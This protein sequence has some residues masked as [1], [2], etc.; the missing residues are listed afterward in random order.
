MSFPFVPR[1]RYDRAL[2]AER[3]TTRH[4]AQRLDSMGTELA[5]VREQLASTDQAAEHEARRKALADALGEDKQHYTWDQLITQV[6]GLRQAG[7]DWMATADRE[8]SRAD[9]LQKVVDSARAR[10]AED[11]E[12]ARPVDGGSA[13]PLSSSARLRREK[14]RA[15]KLAERL[16]EVTA[17]NQAC[18]CAGGDSE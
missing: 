7:I 15:D 17:A 14:G 1:S 2:A 6:A 3:A 11:K 10:A 13:G 9:G 8:R 18:T 16:A 4:V 12:L 5:A